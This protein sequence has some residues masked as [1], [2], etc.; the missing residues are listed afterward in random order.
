MSGHYNQ[1][2]VREEIED[3]LNKIKH[4]INTGKYTLS[5]NDKR[6]ENR[7]FID[8]YHIRNDRQRSILLGIKTD[9]FCHTLQN[10]KK[11]FEHEILYVFV[12]KVMLFNS[13]G[14]E[15]IV[16]IYTKFNLIENPGGGFVVVISF[17]KI[18]K[19]VSYL[20]R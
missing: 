18:N 7:D 10:T 11:G 12:P 9:D 20:F 19:P 16:D 8:E 14:E 1:K 5:M 6:E 3:V 4:C 13:D 2:Y 17:H 15:E